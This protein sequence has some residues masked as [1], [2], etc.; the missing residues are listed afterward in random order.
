MWNIIGETAS[1]KENP[2]V[3]LFLKSIFPS[4]Q[5]ISK[6]YALMYRQPL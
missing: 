6:P 4:W 1:R 3:P 5:G 2:C